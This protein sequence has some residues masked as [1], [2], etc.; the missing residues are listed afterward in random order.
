[1]G[2]IH[3]HTRS[4]VFDANVFCLR[5]CEALGGGNSQ[6]ALVGVH[7]VKQSPGSH[8]LHRQ[9]TLRKHNSSVSTT[10]PRDQAT[11]DQAT[12]DQATPG[13]TRQD[14]AR[15]DLARPG[16]ARPDQTRY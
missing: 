8:P 15:E 5:G 2:S 9:T 14:L 11:P 10:C 4:S 16:Q 7:P 3:I 6:V 1:M 12:P 13:Q